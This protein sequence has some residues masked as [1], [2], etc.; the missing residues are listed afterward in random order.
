M[1]ALSP[2]RERLIALDE[3]LDKEGKNCRS[4]PG[5]CC[6]FAFNS[7][8]ITA[9]EANEILKFLMD[10]KKIN[11]QLQ[12]KIEETIEKFR[13]EIHFSYA[14]KVLRKNYTCP[15]FGQN[16]LGCLLP[17]SI[18]PLGCL[19]F[20]PKEK[21]VTTPGKCYSATEFLENI[22]EEKE[23]IPV[24]IKREARRIGIWELS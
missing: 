8:R 15:F 7:M 10:E 12:L 19:A 18:K 23:T 13:L 16:T 20:V 5:H 24:M 21:D 14:K 4:C 3:A 2:N 11:R 22:E 9:R 1:Q 6:T 17:K